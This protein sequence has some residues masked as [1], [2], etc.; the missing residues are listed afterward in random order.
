MKSYLFITALAIA[1]TASYAQSNT[2]APGAVPTTAS[3]PWTILN[4][5]AGER[6]NI[7]QRQISYCSTMCG[8]PSQAATNFCNATSMAW[9]CVCTN[10]N[11]GSNATYLDPVSFAECNGKSIACSAACPADAQRS[12]CVQSCTNFYSCGT[13]KA[14]ASY[15]QTGNQN[16]TPAYNGPPPPASS[17]ASPSSAINTATTTIISKQSLA[18]KFDVRFEMAGFAAITALLAHAML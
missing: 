4:I 17:S 12:T 6:A 10:S 1:F 14:P 7:C 11:N 3:T 15:L 9:N 5:D 16:D 2:A 18:Y 8:S 13:S